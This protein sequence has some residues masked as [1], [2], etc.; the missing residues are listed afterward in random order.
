[1]LSFCLLQHT[2]P[3]LSYDT[4]LAARRLAICVLLRWTEIYSRSKSSYTPALTSLEFDPDP[5][6]ILQLQSSDQFPL[7]TGCKC[8]AQITDDRWNITQRCH[9]RKTKRT[10]PISESNAFVYGH[11]IVKQAAL[12]L[13]T[14]H[15]SSSLLIYAHKSYDDYSN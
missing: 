13:L 3:K 5:A 1:M 12:T 4:W 11:K 15:V 7:I 8:Y 14:N 6:N 10:Y 2:R 9:T